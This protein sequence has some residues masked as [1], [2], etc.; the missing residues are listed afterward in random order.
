MSVDWSWG[1]LDRL[2][3]DLKRDGYQVDDV[4][5]NTSEPVEEKQILVEVSRN[6]SNPEGD[7]GA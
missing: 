7:D 1:E 3:E 2:V 6:G 4:K 5:T